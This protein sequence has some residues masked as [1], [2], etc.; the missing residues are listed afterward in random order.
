A[1]GTLVQLWDCNGTNAQKW[2]PAVIGGGGPGGSSGGSGNMTV[3]NRCAYTVWVGVQNNA[4]SAL[5]VNGGFQLDAGQSFAFA[6][7]FA[8]GG[9]GGRIWGRTGCNAAGQGCVTGECGQTQCGGNGGRPPA[10]L[11]E[12]TIAQ[13]GLTFYDVSLVDGY[14]VQMRIEAD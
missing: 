12:F 7:P 13:S 8:N 5:P 2:N 9:W 6:T 1:D 4:G 3:V 14:N 11:A 10:T